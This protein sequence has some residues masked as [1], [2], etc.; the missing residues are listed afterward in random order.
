[1]NK[2]KTM[3]VMF[4]FLQEHP[5]NCSE[6]V[7]TFLQGP[8]TW[9]LGGHRAPSL[10]LLCKISQEFFSYFCFNYGTFCGVSVLV[11]F[12]PNDIRISRRERRNVVF[13]EC[14][15]YTRFQRESYQVTNPKGQ[16]PCRPTDMVKFYEDDILPFIALVTRFSVIS[17][18]SLDH[19]LT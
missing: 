13:R 14:Y 8:Y 12:Y 18:Y 11:S 6:S 17:M 4:F 10:L 9:G 3:G 1:M 16:I 15:S 7:G 5:R 19:L 2:K